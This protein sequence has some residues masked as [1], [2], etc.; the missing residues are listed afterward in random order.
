[1]DDLALFLQAGVSVAVYQIK[2]DTIAVLQTS[3]ETEKDLFR[4][5]PELLTVVAFA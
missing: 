1:M 5:S 3:A 2:V 4:I